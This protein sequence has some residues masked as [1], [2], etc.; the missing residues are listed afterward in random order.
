MPF[1]IQPA[2]L[3]EA[4]AKLEARTPVASVLRTAEWRDIPL[5]LRERAFFSAGV[6]SARFLQTAREKLSDALALRKEQVANGVAY[7]DRSSFIGD[8]RK[9][10]LS[11]APSAS[12]R[13]TSP[14]DLTDLA[15]RARLGLIYDTQTQSA[16]GYARWKWDQDPDVL[17]GMPAQELLPSTARVPRED[18]PDRWMAACREAGDSAA[19]AVFTDTGRMVALKTSGVW[20]A[21]NRDFG[22]PWPPF[23]F[24][25]KRQVEDVD[26]TEAEALGLVQAADVLQ[27][28]EAA[29]N[30]ELETSAGNLAPEVRDVL[31][32]LFGG[33]IAFDGDR[34]V[35]QGTPEEY[36]RDR[37]AAADESQALYAR[38]ADR[39]GELGDREQLVST[40]QGDKPL[41]LHAFQTDAEAESLRRQ[42][43]A[44]IPDLEVEVLKQGEQSALVA[45]NPRYHAFTRDQ[46]ERAFASGGGGRE[47]GYGADRGEPDNLLAA[48]YGPDGSA[49]TDFQV[50]KERGRLFAK[51]REQDFSA[52]TGRPHTY[53]ILNPET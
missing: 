36:E 23:A 34:A 8:M 33:Q 17:N 25:S 11:S 35:W 44:A 47:L 20:T 12:P 37:T 15:S 49:I 22:V 43:R 14:Y 50:P 6:E 16:Q 2:P 10:V 3:V 45:W 18:W 38:L 40:A 1:L 19:L 7:V 42:I 27:P 29:F 31:K 13:D 52:A 21:L 26:R 5:A 28:T 48:I 41:Y 32:R 24:G 30:D 51:A 9:L 46:I 39:V 4:V 53:R